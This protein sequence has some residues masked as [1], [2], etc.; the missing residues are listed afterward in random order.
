MT[1]INDLT[2]LAAADLADADVFAVVDTSAG[3][4]KKFQAQYLDR[5]ITTAFARTILD[6]ADAD[7]VLGT[8]GIDVDLAD[9]SLP[10]NTTIS[11]Y[12]ES[13]I[14]DADAEAVAKTLLI[15]RSLLLIEDAAD[16]DKLK[17]TLSSIWNGD[18]DGPTDNIPKNGSAGNYALGATGVTLTVGAGAV[19]G[20]CVAILSAEVISNDTTVKLTVEAIESSSTILISFYKADDA[21]GQ[22]LSS[23]IGG[24]DKAVSV[25]LTYITDA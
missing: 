3:E 5:A 14:D 6:D 20:N 4:T 24:G 8:L 7:T 11:T 15:R 17:C 19:S 21:V 22:D 23:I 13:L 12:G 10:A 18:T 25:H 9:L 2:E 1:N 16:A